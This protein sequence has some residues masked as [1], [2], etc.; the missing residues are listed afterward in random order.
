[1]RYRLLI[2]I[3]LAAPVTLG[4][5][6][7]APEEERADLHRD[8]ERVDES[9]IPAMRSRLRRLLVG[10]AESPRDGDPHIR[11]GAAQGLGDLHD[12]ED[13]DVLLEALMGPLADEGVLVRIECAIALGK[14]WYPERMDERRQRV[15]LSLRSRVAF[16]RDDS[17]RALESEYLVRSAM[18]SSLVAIGGRDAAAALHDIASRLLSDIEDAQGIMYTAATDRGLLDRCFAGLADVTGVPEEEAA[19]N[20]F[21]N[22][23][24]TAHIDWWTD[25]IADMPE[26]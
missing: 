22:D 19:Q 26:R 4:G 20:R 2:L 7:N 14:L 12:P 8:V 3:L 1:M 6:R 11:S 25:R 23:D 9:E 16:D 21:E 15:I 18:V 5:C 10:D 17:G 24:L 13:A